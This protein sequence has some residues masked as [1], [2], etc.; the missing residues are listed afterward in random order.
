M[1]PIA[2]RRATIGATSTGPS[3]RRSKSYT[4]PDPEILDFVRAAL[5]L[6]LVEWSPA[7]D[8]DE[9]LRFA[10][11]FQQYT[12]PVMAKAMEDTSFYRYNRLLSL[13]EVGGDPRQFGVT[14]SAFH[15]LMQERAKSWPHAMSASS[16]HDTKR[17]A[18]MRARLNVLSELA[19]EWNQ[20]VRRWASLNRF[21]RGKVDGD[22]AP[23]PNDEYGDLSDLARRMAV[24]PARST[25]SAND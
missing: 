20:R 22:P 9:V 14:I 7:F 4:G 6:D 10:M 8:R 3:S 2:A 15:H 19:P 24:R 11:R 25:H 17:G 16:T 21:K 1:S 23:S 18:D 13:N 5:T 12:G